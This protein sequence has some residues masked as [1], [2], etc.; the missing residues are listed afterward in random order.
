MDSLE[1]R[2]TDF[3]TRAGTEFK[4]LRTLIN[5]NMP[6]LSALTT[7]AKASLVGAVNELKGAIDTVAASVAAMIS[8]TAT[9]TAHV[10]SASKS[11][12]YTDAAVAAI[13]GGADAAYQTLK[14]IETFLQAN[15]GTI[16]TLLTEL[17]LCIR[18][19]VA[20]TLTAA[21]QLQA[22]TNLDVYGKT[23][24]GDPNTNLVAIFEAALS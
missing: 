19:D 11:K 24:I 15:S 3:A 16:T 20:Q 22:R 14:E 1:S 21:Q 7:L 8:D 12:S 2:M 13:L 10:W 17:G 23:D 4:A 5:G 6:D 9:D 18:S